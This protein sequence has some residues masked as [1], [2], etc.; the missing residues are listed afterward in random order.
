MAD[1]SDLDFDAIWDAATEQERR[2][3][4]DELIEEIEVRGDHLGV[5]IQG[6]PRLNVT[7][8]E[9]GLKEPN[10]DRSC[11]RS[12]RVPNAHRY[13]GANSVGTSTQT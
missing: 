5:V 9:V 10:E 4:I 6:A 1:L 12:A 8:G 13:Y 2:T 3:L 11:R 7:L